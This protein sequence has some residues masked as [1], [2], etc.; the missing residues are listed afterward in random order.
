M[1]YYTLFIGSLV[2][3]SILVSYCSCQTNQTGALNRYFI[4][5]WLLGCIPVWALVSYFSKNIVFD[6]IVYDLIILVVYFAALLYF[7]GKA[8]EFTWA[9]LFFLLLMVIGGIGFKL[10]E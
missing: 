10:S 3:I 1:L 2:G 7:S 4:I 6:G 9:Q 8:V 5:T